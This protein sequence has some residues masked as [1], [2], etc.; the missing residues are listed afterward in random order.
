MSPVSVEVPVLILIFC[1]LPWF[2]RTMKGS[3]QTFCAVAAQTDVLGKIVVLAALVPH[4]LFVAVTAVPPEPFWLKRL[5]APA[6]WEIL[7]AKR[8]KLMVAGIPAV[9][10]YMPP[11][12]PVPVPA[13]PDALFP[14]IVTFVRE[15]LVPAFPLLYQTPPPDA[16]AVLLLMTAL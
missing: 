3:K 16:P 11:P 6:T 9:P 12:T 8:L 7:L 10:T 13:V 15:A 1:G 2:V 4:Q 5:L 14:V